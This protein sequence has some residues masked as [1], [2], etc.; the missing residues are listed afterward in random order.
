MRVR[1]EKRQAAV[2]ELP[3]DTPKAQLTKM[4]AALG[5]GWVLV[6]GAK[7]R[8]RPPKARSAALKQQQKRVRKLQKKA[9]AAVKKGPAKKKL[10]W[11]QRPENAERAR[12]VAANA[13]AS[14]RK[15]G[16]GEAKLGETGS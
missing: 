3:D 11:T 5:Q 6:A 1:F 8:G 10:H 16:E 14:R 13:T 12:L 7:R 2:F 15:T 9:K 4:A